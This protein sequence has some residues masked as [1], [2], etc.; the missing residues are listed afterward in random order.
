MRIDRSDSADEPEDPYEA[1]SARSTPDDL[2]ATGKDRGTAASGDGSP[3]SSPASSDTAMRT[4]R[5][6]VHCDKVNAA[7]RQYAIDCGYAPEERR[8]RETVAPAVRPIEVEDPKPRPVGLNDRLKG[9]DRPT[10][11]EHLTKGETRQV[12]TDA[13]ALAS[14]IRDLTI[15]GNRSREYDLVPRVPVLVHDCDLPEGYSSSPALK[16]DPYHPDAVSERSK[17]NQELYA[18]TS[19]DR[20]ADLGYN[21]RIPA[22]KAPFD[23]H[24]QEVFTSGK[25]YITPDVDGHN[26]TNGWKMFNR[27]GVRIGTYDSELNYVKE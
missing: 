18:A 7:Y 20:A 27:R 24:S 9:K 21:T 6:T 19:R 26:V 4:D 23:S 11:S 2:D 15:P 5:F 14:G 17:A 3:H 22:Q 1:R 12:P 13:A 10:E 8:E 25:S 16:G